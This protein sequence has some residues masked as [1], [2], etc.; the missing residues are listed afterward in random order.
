[1]KTEQD[2]LNFTALRTGWHTGHGGRYVID[3]RAFPRSLRRR[4]EDLLR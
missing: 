4:V 3:D 2:F 1:M